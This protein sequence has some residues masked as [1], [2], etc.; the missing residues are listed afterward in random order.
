MATSCS[1]VLKASL[2][3]PMEIIMLAASQFPGYESPKSPLRLMDQHFGTICYVLESECQQHSAE[4]SSNKSS[5]FY[6]EV[7]VLT[8]PLL[9]PHTKTVPDLEWVQVTLLLSLSQ[10]NGQLQSCSL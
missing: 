7:E 2:P 8:Y 9:Q 3:P 6:L 4:A 1:F 10:F 5:S